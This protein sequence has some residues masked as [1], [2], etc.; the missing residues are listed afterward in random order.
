MPPKRMKPCRHPGGCPAL[1][2]DR[3]GL[4]DAHRVSGW[5]AHQAG[6]S[7]HQRG[8]G[9]EWDKLRRIIFRKPS[10]TH[11]FFLSSAAHGRLDA[12]NGIGIV[13]LMGRESGF[14]AAQSALA[15]REANFVL[16][17]EAPFQL[18]G[19]GG[20]LPALER[21][22]KLRGHAVIIAAEGA[23][24]HLLQQNEARDAS[25]NPVLSDVGSLLRTS[26]VDYFHG[27][28]PISIK[29]IDPS[30][31]IRSVPANANDRIYCGFLGQNAVHA[32]MAAGVDVRGYFVWS[33][34]DNF[35]WS[36][37]YE[38][39]FGI[40]HVDYATQARTPKHSA[41]ALKRFLAERRA[42]AT[43]T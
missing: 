1:T 23:G 15:L 3:S 26:I 34:L 7:R 10:R 38:A 12:F 2:A 25:G 18:H 30:Y 19:D 41:L 37:G 20:L 39:R 24:Q 35:E 17:P 27:K 11:G 4:C 29:Y 28:M 5:V 22:L 33:L 40:V 14:I 16:I 43:S 31:I 9:K 42:N 36:Y 8:Y 13:K 21:R 6:K 32:A